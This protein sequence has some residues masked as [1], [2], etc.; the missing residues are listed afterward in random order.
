MNTIHLYQ[1]EIP[2][3]I[4]HKERYTYCLEFLQRVVMNRNYFLL[5][6]L[7]SRRV[8]LGNH[9]LSTRIALS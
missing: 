8:S 9:P 6:S 1:M 4:S 3:T 2:Y 7:Y 5:H